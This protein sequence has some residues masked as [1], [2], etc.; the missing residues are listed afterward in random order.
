MEEASFDSVGGY[1][2]L[3]KQADYAFSAKEWP[4]KFKRVDDINFFSTYV[5]M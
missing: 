3:G 2:K 4:R 1:K 5:H